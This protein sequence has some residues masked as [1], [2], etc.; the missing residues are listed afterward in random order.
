MAAL[1]YW[2]TAVISFSAALLVLMGLIRRKSPRAKSDD[3]LKWLG[4]TLLVALGLSLIVVVVW[5]ARFKDR[6]FQPILFALPLYFAL[7]AQSRLSTRGFRVLSTVAG[8]VAIATLV[9]LPIIPISAQLTKRPTRLNLPYKALASAL[10]KEGIEPLT[11][12]ADSRLTGGNLKLQFPTATVTVPELRGPINTR[13]NVLV[14]WE[15]KRKNPL[16]NTLVELVQE[17]GVSSQDLAR[18]SHVE[19]PLQFMTDEKVRWDYVLVRRQ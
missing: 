9:I 1:G 12:A 8:A 17:L 11:I 13:D 10:R 14:I 6:W 19:L 7:W 5:K 3:F 2:F 16:P 4:R 18:A 15:A